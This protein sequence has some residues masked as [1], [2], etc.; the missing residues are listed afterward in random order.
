MQWETTSAFQVLSAAGILINIKIPRMRKWKQVDF[1]E[2]MK[3]VELCN[4][5][6]NTTMHR[7]VP[8]LRKRVGLD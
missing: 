3:Y 2:Y 4:V 7:F 8:A 6:E 1:D 5:K